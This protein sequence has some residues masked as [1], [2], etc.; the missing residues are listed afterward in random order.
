M[1][2]TIAVRRRR[3]APRPRAPTVLIM[4]QLLQSRALLHLFLL[5]LVWGSSHKV[6]FNGVRVTAMSPTLLRIEPVGPTGF[7]DSSTF[8]VVNRTTFPGVPLR[9]EASNLTHITLVTQFYAV[10]LRTPAPPLQPPP[11]PPAPLPSA[12]DCSGGG[13]P[14]YSVRGF[15]GYTP[16]RVSSCAAAAQSCLAPNATLSDCCGNCT[17]EME[18]TTWVYKSSTTACL[19]YSAGHSL[20]RDKDDSIAGGLVSPNLG[21]KTGISASVLSPDGTLLWH[22]DDLAAVGQELNW[23]SPLNSTAYAVKDFPRFFVPKWGAAP[24]PLS[25]KPQLDP[26]LIATNGYDFRINCNG[27]VYVFLLGATLDSWWAARSE[28]VALSGPTPVLPDFAFGTCASNLTP[29]HPPLPSFPLH[30]PPFH[31]QLRSCVWRCADCAWLLCAQGSPFGISTPRLKP[32]KRFSA[33]T[34]THCLSMCGD[35]I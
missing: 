26:A 27:D 24:V 14:G 19:L 5:E 9:T 1:S 16:H 34:L 32:S 30:P 28:F 13:V 33:G 4:C 23:P 29:L 12:P 25:E 10:R 18:C 3:A 22:A 7:V 17:G 35:W 20:E 11:P 31:T 21:P 15:N 8:V 6:I 2:V